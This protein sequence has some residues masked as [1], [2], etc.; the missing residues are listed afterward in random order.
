MAVVR[1]YRVG[2]VVRRRR[3][4]RHQELMVRLRPEVVG[5]MMGMSEELEEWTGRKVKGTEG[6]M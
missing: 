6:L 5:K 1:R 4:R 3:V 2:M